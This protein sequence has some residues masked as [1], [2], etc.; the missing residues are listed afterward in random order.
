MTQFEAQDNNVSNMGTDER[1]YITDLS[2]EVLGYI[3]GEGPNGDRP[4]L[5][6]RES[7]AEIKIGREHTIIGDIPDYGD[8]KSKYRT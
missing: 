2:F 3:I 1:T 6:K 4:K 8:G 7:A 5:I